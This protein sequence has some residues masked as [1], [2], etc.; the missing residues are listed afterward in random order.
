MLMLIIGI[1][2]WPK[3]LNNPLLDLVHEQS[4]D[5]SAASH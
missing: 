4:I 5:S 2:P 1:V 3:I